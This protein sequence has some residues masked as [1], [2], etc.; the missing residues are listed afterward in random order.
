MGTKVTQPSFLSGEISPALQG[1]VDLPA[2]LSGLRV[3][4]NFIVQREGGLTT[5]PGTIFRGEVKDSTKRVRLLPFQIANDEGFLLEVGHLYTRV[6]KRGQRIASV[7]LA[8]EWTEAEL[9]RIQYVQSADVLTAAQAGHAPKE[10]RHY[11]DNDWRLADLSYT[12]T[13]PAPTN[14]RVSSIADA[15]GTS[16]YPPDTYNYIVCAVSAKGERSL[17]SNDLAVSA[18]LQ[19]NKPVSVQWDAP[20]GPAPESYEVYRASNGIY[21]YIGSTPANR[22]VFKDKNYVPVYG[23]TPPVVYTPYTDATNYPACLTLC[24]QRLWFGREQLL[25]SSAS[26]NYHDFTAGSPPADDDACRTAIASQELNEIR[27]LLPLEV[28]LAF[29]TG[30]IWAFGGGQDGTI[31]PSALGEQRLAKVGTSWLSPLIISKGPICVSVSN[32]I[33]WDLAPTLSSGNDPFDLCVRA[34]HLF[35]RRQ[36]VD[37][38]FQADPFSV[39]WCVTSDG[40][41]FGLTLL[42]QDEVWAWHRHDTD[43]FVESICTLVEDAQNV[44]YLIVRRTVDGVEKRY[45]EQLAPRYPDDPVNAVAVDCAVQY[46]GRNTSP[47]TVTVAGTDLGLGA[48]VTVTASAPT[49]S[50]GDVGAAVRLYLSDDPYDCEITGYTSPTDVSAIVRRTLADDPFQPSGSGAVSTSHWALAR[51]IITGLSHLEGRLVTGLADGSVIPVTL[52]DGGQVA[53]DDWAA[54]ATVGL[55]YQCE[56]QTLNLT[57]AGGIGLK[58]RKKLVHSVLV[59]VAET[60][61]LL[62]GEDS[63]S[64]YPQEARYPN[65]SYFDPPPAE[66]AEIKFKISS[67]WNL[68]GQVLIRQ[69]DPLPATILS[70][71]PEVTVGG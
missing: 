16:D 20:T 52:V 43:G 67:S 40:L 24:Q 39:V 50:A 7:E 29:T 6:W 55:G 12:P 8:T 69:D 28:L 13:Q 68:G 70:I 60:R 34:A 33:I 36:I 3:C 26:G 2:Y 15:T 19:T 48:T 14:L 62:V 57:V 27:N 63:E 41:V 59:Q 47:T 51:R 11:A 56:A 18:N 71:Q 31:T 49:F 58:G 66:T 65:S 44:V 53:L 61:G 35:R 23:Q 22:T 30:A 9:A 38:C 21:G 17:A 45:L 54:V 4:R 5:R 46:D 37:W 42:R 10:I 1:R 64:L 25:L 32:R